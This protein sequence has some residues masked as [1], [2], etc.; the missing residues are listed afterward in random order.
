[1]YSKASEPG[2]EAPEEKQVIIGGH[3]F[4][5]DRYGRDRYYRMSQPE[6]VC[7][8]TLLKALQ[9]PKQTCSMK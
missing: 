1:M 8:E 4:N 3:D 7:S 2:D 6:T 9:L 5:Q